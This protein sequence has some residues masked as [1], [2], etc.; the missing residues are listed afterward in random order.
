[1]SVSEPMFKAPIL[2]K[3]KLSDVDWTSISTS[4]DYV[5]PKDAK[6]RN[7]Q[8]LVVFEYI[9]EE[10]AKIGG[11]AV[12]EVDND[13][14]SCLWIPPSPSDEDEKLF[15]VY[16]AHMLQAGLISNP[17]QLIAN[18]AYAG[19]AAALAQSLM[20][21]NAAGLNRY[22]AERDA[23]QLALAVPYYGAIWLSLGLM[24]VANGHFNGAVDALAH[25]LRMEPSNVLGLKYMSI[26][27]TLS[28]PED[29]VRY[30]ERLFEALAVAGVAP[31]VHSRAAYGYAL[32][33]AGMS[34][35]AAQQFKMA[36][37][38]GKPKMTAKQWT[39]WGFSLPI[40]ALPIAMKDPPRGRG[41]A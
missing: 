19:S 28:S 34:V 14:C 6:D 26:V 36:C 40:E 37:N 41:L 21:I 12:V 20:M 1:M 39:E 29:A 30:A 5:P 9:T 27:H 7:N 22:V 32:Q 3:F 18:T 10:L 11:M 8:S 33:R 13:E 31:D 2:S 24:L 35:E 25:L 17:M 16:V 23:V 38:V 15:L 4:K